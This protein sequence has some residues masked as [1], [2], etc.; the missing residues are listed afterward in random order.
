LNKTF[1]TFFSHFLIKAPGNS[2]STVNK[3]LKALNV[4]CQYVHINEGA[5][6]SAVI[7]KTNRL[8]TDIP[9]KTFLTEQEL[10][11]V[12]NLNLNKYP[13]LILARD[14]FLFGC[15]TGLKYTDIQKLKNS[16]IVNGKIKI[17]GAFGTEVRIPLNNYANM[18]LNK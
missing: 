17:I 15:F 13:N 16:D 4:F 9:N 12:F 1:G 8:K 14:L 10:S 6:V 3:K 18:I 2:N 7:D 11:K 5:K